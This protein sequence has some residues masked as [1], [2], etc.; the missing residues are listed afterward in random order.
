MR[1]SLTVP[2]AVVAL[3]FS[4]PS[5]ALSA[6]SPPTPPPNATSATLDSTRGKL[7]LAVDIG[8]Q[9]TSQAR[10][11]NEPTV[12]DGGGAGASSTC[13]WVPIGPV[14]EVQAAQAAVNASAMPDVAD[15]NITEDII[16]GGGRA[17]DRIIEQ[18]W[19]RVSG[20]SAQIRA[21]ET[22]NGVA[23]GSRWFDL[24]PDASGNLVIQI[25]AEDL[26]PGAYDRVV[27]QLPTPVPRIGP[28]D[29][30]EDGYAYV[31]N[32][33]FFWLDQ[34]PGQWNPVTATASAGGISVTVTA[35][36]VRL[37]VDPGN[38]DG[39][40]PCDSFVPVLRADVRAN[41]LPGDEAC[42]YTYTDSSAMAPN[43]Q[44]W[45]VTASIVWHVTWNA[46]TGQAGDLGYTSTASP[47]RDLPVAEIQAIVTESADGT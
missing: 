16:Q 10:S 46:N 22:C 32:R 28:A 31:Q 2:F 13:P 23:G 12:A 25:T 38:G 39:P 20:T 35:Q 42:S 24:V 44:T 27:R 33:T 43:G 47:P 19:Y 45:P 3:T 21:R 8:G 17:P 1:T 37:S 11:I 26:V 34:A 40:V 5:A 18:D 9:S 29:E 15:P 14:A 4:L 30:D 41:G 36:P 7:V 6:A